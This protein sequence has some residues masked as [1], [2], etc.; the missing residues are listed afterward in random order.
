LIFYCTIGINC[1]FRDVAM[2]HAP[3]SHRCVVL[4]CGNTLLGD[5][6]FGPRVIE[7]LESQIHLFDTLSPLQVQLVDAGTAGYGFLFD[8]LLSD[9][10]PE[11]VIVV[12]AVDLPGKRPG[13][14]FE[15]DMDAISPAKAVDFSPHQFPGMNLLKEIRDETDIRTHVLAVQISRIP[16]EIRP[17]LSGPV[18][19]AV[20]RMCA[21]IADRLKTSIRQGMTG[22]ER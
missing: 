22:C 3:S 8:I 14:V 15:I 12:D 5:D 10:R 9:P 4:G 6:G 18:E 1:I 17:G 13:E 11:T 21:L 16:D 20:P 7:A 19:R 2:H